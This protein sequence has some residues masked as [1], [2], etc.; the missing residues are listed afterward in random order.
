MKKN[1]FLII[2]AQ[3][4]FCNPNGALYVNGAE[5]DMEKLANIIQTQGEKIDDI[6]VT[7]DTHIVNDIAHPACWED[8]KG[9]FPPPF[10]PITYADIQAGK[11]KA[12]FSPEICHEYVKKLEKQ[13]QFTHFIWTEHCILGSRGASLDDTLFEALKNWSRKFGKTYHKEEKG[14]YPF[15]EHFGAFMAQIPRDNFRETYLNTIF[16]EKLEEYDNVFVCGE[17]KSHC[18]ATSIKQAMELYP[19]LAEKMVILEDCMSDV[20]NLGH[21][22]EPIYAEA[23]QQGIRFAKIETLILT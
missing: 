8:E 17:A 11:W 13:G 16:M 3:Y 4:D 18:V 6:F 20:P 19:E 12:R 21:L 2:D 7:L 14:L 10:T 1:A 15:S 9:N 5:K 22:G 23:R